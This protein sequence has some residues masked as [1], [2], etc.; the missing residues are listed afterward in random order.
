MDK[1]QETCGMR[2]KGFTLIELLVVIAII[3]IL[4][5]ILLPAL[6]TVR[7][8]GKRR[9]CASQVRQHLLALTVYAD[10]YK[11]KLPLAEPGGWL[12]D[13]NT[14][15]VDAMQKSGLGMK[16]FF[17]PSNIIMHNHMLHFWT[18]GQENSPRPT[19]TLRWL[20]YCYILKDKGGART[21]AMITLPWDGKRGK[22]WCTSVTD[23]YASDRELVIDATIS[24]KGSR[25]PEDRYPNGNFAMVMSG[26]TPGQYAVPDSTNHIKKDY[27]PYGGNMG[28]LD[29]H[30][31]WRKFGNPRSGEDG[32]MFKRFGGDGNGFWW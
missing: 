20:G 7:E 22:H 18:A 2:N 31:E 23:K 10:D 4:M 28:F 14:S 26:A 32:V 15:V 9:S 8:Q 12:W 19:N 30:V 24:E 1:K 16:M 3:A 11:G 29:G 13:L 6:S 21:D 27:V 17:C 25:W 5:G